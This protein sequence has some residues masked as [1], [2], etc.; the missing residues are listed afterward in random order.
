[1]YG[2]NWP[3]DGEIDAVEINIG[4][5]YVTWHYGDNNSTIGTGSW[6]GQVVYP[7]GPN[8]KP[9]VWETVDI[10]FGSDD[11][12]IF[13]NGIHYV[14]IPQNLTPA[15]KD[16]MYFTLSEGSCEAEGANVCV[17]GSQGV[18]SPGKMLVNYVREFK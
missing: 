9:N 15:G 8:I 3:Q 18:D 13:Y 4:A 11:I 14:S 12:Q 7:T 10:L 5:N 16:P 6:N 2:A 17:N 1:M